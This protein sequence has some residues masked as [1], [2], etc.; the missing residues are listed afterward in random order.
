MWKLK[1]RDHCPQLAERGFELCSPRT[2]EASTARI[3][4]AQSVLVM[5]GLKG[6]RYFLMPEECGCTFK[7]H[8]DCTNLQDWKGWP[9][10]LF[11]NLTFYW[12]RA[13]NRV[14]LISGGQQRNSAILHISILP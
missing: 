2:T 14:V 13:I 9:L 1:L 10:T 5:K 4:T 11:K 8:I 7:M 3:H 6:S 12:G